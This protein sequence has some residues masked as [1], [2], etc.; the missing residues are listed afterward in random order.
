MWQCWLF[1]PL[2][3][4][5][6]EIIHKIFCPKSPCGTILTAEELNYSWIPMKPSGTTN[7]KRETLKILDYTYLKFIS[8][9]IAG[10]IGTTISQQIY[11]LYFDKYHKTVAAWWILAYIW[12]SHKV[13]NWR[14]WEH[15]S[16]NTSVMLVSICNKVL[17]ISH[18]LV[19]LYFITVVRMCENTYI[20]C[21]FGNR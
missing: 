7:S 12:L 17:I 19:L 10:K 11:G 6:P 20:Q 13:Q 2:H 15:S 14:T 1:V 18:T 4:I 3:S 8:Q 21:N 5:P 9:N 16:C